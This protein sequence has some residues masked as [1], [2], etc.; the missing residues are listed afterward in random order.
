MKEKNA[1]NLKD[2]EKYFET[3]YKL[4]K[5]FGLASENM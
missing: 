4:V 2:I 5:W 3:F 1:H